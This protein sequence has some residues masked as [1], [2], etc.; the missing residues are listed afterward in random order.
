MT[1]SFGLSIL[2]VLAVIFLSKTSRNTGKRKF[3]RGI[4]RKCP[5]CK[6]LIP[7]TAT[8]CPQCTTPIKHEPGF[9]QIMLG[10]K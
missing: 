10:A 9:V 5:A 3:A 8:V 4:T 7:D 2:V 1:L 6:T